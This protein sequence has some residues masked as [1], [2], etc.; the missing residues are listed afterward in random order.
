MDLREPVVRKDEREAEVR[1]VRLMPRGQE[2]AQGLGVDEGCLGEVD[3]DGQS[4]VEENLDLVG[5][6]A[7][8]VG[9]VL[10]NERDDSD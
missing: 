5:D 8:R 3:H 2:R 1:R 9:V 10:A 6:A 7:G 4:R